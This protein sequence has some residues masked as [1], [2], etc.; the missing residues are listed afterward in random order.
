MDIFF[1]KSYRKAANK[2][3]NHFTITTM[4]SWNEIPI[5]F[6]LPHCLKVTK[7]TSSHEQ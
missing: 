5:M 6:G 4:Q 7:K 2:L 3:R 1:K